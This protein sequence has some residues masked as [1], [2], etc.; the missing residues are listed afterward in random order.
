MKD[1]NLLVWVTQLGISVAIPLAAFIFLG[2]WLHESCG[3]GK[4]ALIAG[5]V[6]G[7]LSA[8]NGFVSSMKALGTMSK[9]KKDQSPPPLSFNDHD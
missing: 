9:D 7:A 2:K 3:W 8:F 4:W 6:L 1:L 5:I